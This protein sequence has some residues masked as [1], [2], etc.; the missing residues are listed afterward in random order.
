MYTRTE[1]IFQDSRGPCGCGVRACDTAERE[2][3]FR[4]DMDR[5][6]YYDASGRYRAHVRN[7]YCEYMDAELAEEIEEFKTSLRQEYGTPEPAAAARGGHR[8]EPGGVGL[9]PGDKHHQSRGSL[10]PCQ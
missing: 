4:T 1:G 2:H 7:L 5:A 9:Q 8:G 10:G 6:M 3:G